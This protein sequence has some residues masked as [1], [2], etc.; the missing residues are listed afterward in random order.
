MGQ[1]HASTTCM[2]DAFSVM[3]SDNLPDGDDEEAPHLS[4]QATLDDDMHR[5][6]KEGREIAYKKMKKE[7]DKRTKAKFESLQMILDQ[8]IIDKAHADYANLLN[9]TA[10]V[11]KFLSDMELVLDRSTLSLD[12]LNRLNELTK[13]LQALN[14]HDASL[15]RDDT[16]GYI[17]RSL[18]QQMEQVF[19][20]RIEAQPPYTLVFLGMLRGAYYR[21]V[22]EYQTGEHA[23]RSLKASVMNY[24]AAVA[25][26]HD[27]LLPRDVVRLAAEVEYVAFTRTS[28]RQPE[29]SNALFYAAITSGI[30]VYAGILNSSD[31]KDVKAS[32]AFSRYMGVI[33]EADLDPLFGCDPAVLWDTALSKA[34]TEA[35]RAAARLALLSGNFRW[36]MEPAEA[37][38]QVNVITGV[39]PNELDEEP[40]R[41]E[42]YSSELQEFKDRRARTP[43]KRNSGPA[44]KGVSG[45]AAD[46]KEAA[47][48]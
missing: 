35:A 19:G 11:H 25:L 26:A 5:V 43:P 33:C 21:L 32:E 6:L 9:N 48:E 42:S 44:K 36:S 29:R 12:N 17:V 45:A 46:A 18:Q 15:D 13:K 27:R 47:G 16:L 10:E 23:A 2:T 30:D 8:E 4:T 28:F 40:R 38:A 3:C 37:D 31:E 24:N 14:K 1:A 41:S 20:T 39:N 34:E 22:S 7:C